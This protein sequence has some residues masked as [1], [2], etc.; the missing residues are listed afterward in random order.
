MPPSFTLAP[1]CFHN[2]ITSGQTVITVGARK[3]P[4]TSE[5]SHSKKA[6][7]KAFDRAKKRKQIPIINNEDTVKDDLAPKPKKK[8]TRPPKKRAGSTS[9]AGGA[10]PQKKVLSREA[11]DLSFQ[12]KECSKNKN[13]AEALSLFWDKNKEGIRDQFHASI[14]IDCCARCGALDEINRIL[15]SLKE[16]A[17]VE[18]NTG[19]MKGYCHGGDMRAA[20]Q[21]FDAM[22]KAKSVKR[23]P[24][25]RTL[26]TLLRGCL[27]T[28]A[29]MN[30]DDQICGGVVTA[31]SAWGLYEKE[32]ATRVNEE[33]NSSP[34]SYEYTICLLCQA[35]CTDEAE[36][37]INAFQ[38]VC[39]IRI[40]KKQIVGGDQSSLET[41]AISYSALAR[42]KALLGDKDG[43]LD[44]C[45]LARRMMKASG[46]RQFALE[47]KSLDGGERGAVGGSKRG[48][49]DTTDERRNVSNT[50]F[51]DHRMSELE[52]N[53]QTLVELCQSPQF[54]PPKDLLATRMTNGLF[55]FS[56][57]G[58]TQINDQTLS[59]EGFNSEASQ[60]D[61][62]EQKDRE[63]SRAR[64][65]RRQVANSSWLS[66]GLK[67][68]VALSGIDVKLSKDF[69]RMKDSERLFRLVAKNPKAIQDNGHIDFGAIFPE[70]I[71]NID[72]ELGSGYG[73]W[74]VNQAAL[75]PDRNH[76]AVELRADRVHQIFAKGMLHPAGALQNLAV[77]GDDC[78]AFLSERVKP[79]SVSTIFAN[80]PEPP[81]QVQGK[82][83]RDLQAIMEGGPEPAHMLCSKTL[84]AAGN[85]LQDS[86][87]SSG[88][89][90]IIIVTDNVNYGRLICATVVRMNRQNLSA[91]R[92]CDISP[93][94]LGLRELES[95]SLDDS[96]P[97]NGRVLLLEGQPSHKIGHSVPRESEKG[98]GSSYFDRLW[99]TGACGHASNRERYILVL[100]LHS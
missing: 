90:R 24:N 100:E 10:T 95:F 7:A 59:G 49:K 92:S 57:G 62:K 45:T 9:A 12:L 28:A 21:L 31:E 86:K 65:L 11:L 34:P 51:R 46:E 2:T 3:M 89:G 74:I 25:I 94:A 32:M 23:K 18:T 72:I 78:S 70:N 80:H 14:A 64:H 91:L 17:S 55:Y 41:L 99:R 77:V 13:L 27:W 58:T 20:S 66:F 48:W 61:P 73:E 60:S 71:N 67:A 76:V 43:A 15:K 83:D 4:P 79:K 8:K 88:G 96:R 26:N 5:E 33:Q 1:S 30:T 54:P 44:A 35:L 97:R 19:A 36:K 81:T 53:I 82:S 16:P 29:T 47:N 39:D 75:M 68:A 22:L 56:G 50:K 63:M 69:L 37:R 52:M 98:G 87:S 38:T 42:A 85:L 6:F 84:I 93:K 40:S